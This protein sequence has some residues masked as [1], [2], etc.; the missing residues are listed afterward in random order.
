MDVLRVEA[1]D[2]PIVTLRYWAALR[3]AA[4]R[5]GDVV[6]LDAPTTLAE[7]RARVRERYDDRFARV[8]DV[9]SVLVEEQ[10]AG[11]GSGADVVVRPGQTVDFLPPFAGG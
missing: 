3:S 1:G 11:R 6:R 8:L 7:L 2:G 10:P 5:E 4:G 9:C